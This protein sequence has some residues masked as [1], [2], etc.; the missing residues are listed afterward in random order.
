MMR[1]AITNT[2][3][4]A[5]RERLEDARNELTEE[6]LNPLYSRSDR[7]RPPRD[8]RASARASYTE[9]YRNVRLPARR[10][11]RAV[12]RVPRLDRAAVGGGRRQTS[13]AAR[14]GVGLGEAQRWDV[15]PR[16]PRRRVGRRIPRRPH[17]ARARGDARR[18]RRRPALAENVQLDLEDRPNKTPRAFCVPIE[19]PG[20]VML[21]I[22]P[23]GGPDDWHA[24][25][26]EAGHTEHYAHTSRVAV[27]GGEAPRRQRRHRGLGDA[28]RAPRHR[29]G[30]AQR[31]LDFPRPN[32][33]GA[34]GAVQLLWLVRRYCAKLLYEIELHAGVDVRRLR[35]RYAELLTA[36]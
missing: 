12:P 25:F 36:R 27:G 30:L 20:R 33:F 11:R 15:G 31:R 2:A 24:L 23:N 13:S 18:P 35:H 21:V 32:E 29:P 14:L 1:P 34:E 8:R 28:D 10:A 26:H 3:E 7:R 5:K 19:V 17:A 9:L 22:K 16:L 4:R 6:H